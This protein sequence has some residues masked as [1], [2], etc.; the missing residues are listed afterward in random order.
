MGAAGFSGSFVPL[1]GV[2]LK[3][4]I[5]LR[6]KTEKLEFGGHVSK[7]HVIPSQCAHWRGNPLVGRE[8]YRKPV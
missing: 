8:T 1:C 4:H 6:Q 7:N 2:A 5:D 3:I